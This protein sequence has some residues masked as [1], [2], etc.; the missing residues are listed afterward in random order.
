MIDAGILHQ[1]RVVLRQDRA[2]PPSPLRLPPGARFLA[3]TECRIAQFPCI[4]LY[5]F[6]GRVRRRSPAV[7]SVRRLCCAR[8][9]LLSKV[10]CLGLSKPARKTRKS[11]GG[12]FMKSWLTKTCLVSALALLASAGPAL[13][14]AGGN[15][16]E[17]ARARLQGGA[18]FLQGAEGPGDGRDPGRRHWKIPRAMS[19]SYFRVQSHRIVGVRQERQFHPRD[20]RPQLLRLPLRPCGARRL[21]GQYLDRRRRHQHDHQVQPR[22]QQ[23]P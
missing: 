11:P 17:R 4:I 7:N 2:A 6:C 15:R 8:R 19:S 14:P 21:P 10:A 22:R 1:L 12:I 9:L 23:D 18:Q 5:D 3:F 13:P 20:R 16:P